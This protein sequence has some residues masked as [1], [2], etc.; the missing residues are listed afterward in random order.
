[1]AKKKKKLAKR[2]KSDMGLVADRQAI[3][4][5]VRRIRPTRVKRTERDA[6]VRL[7]AHAGPA[8]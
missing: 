3:D 6:N 1:M 7:R 4:P 2:L 8:N 5:H